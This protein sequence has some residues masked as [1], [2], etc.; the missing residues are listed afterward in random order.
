MCA[1]T[2]I[3]SKNKTCYYAS[4]YQHIQLDV[5]FHVYVF[6]INVIKMVKS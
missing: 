6:R 3:Q 5:C 4:I 1:G 2:M